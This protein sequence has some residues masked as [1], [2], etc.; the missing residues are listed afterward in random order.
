MAGAGL[1]A[2]ATAAPGDLVAGCERGRSFAMNAKCAKADPRRNET[3]LSGGQRSPSL[4][5]K[6]IRPPALLCDRLGR[7]RWRNLAR[8]ASRRSPGML[9]GPASSQ[10]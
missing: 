7:V 2:I 6:S 5:G 3:A 9:D 10:V 1:V 8:R 4:R